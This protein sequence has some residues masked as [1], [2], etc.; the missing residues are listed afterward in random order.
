MKIGLDLAGG[1]LAPHN[2]IEAVKLF[3]EEHSEIEILGVVSR[4]ILKKEKRKLKSLGIQIIEVENRISMEMK[5]TEALKVKN[6]NLGTLMEL[7][8]RK[9]VNAVVS[10]G[11]TG[12]VMAF[13]MTLLGR[14]KGVRRPAL[15]SLFPTLNGSC[16]LIDAGA[17]VDVKPLHLYHFAIMGSIVAKEI[18]NKEEPTVGLLNVGTEETKGSKK[19]SEAFEMLKK[20]KLNFIGN[21]EGNHITRGDADVV[22]CDGFAGN[23]I[24][25]FGEGLVELIIN[26]IKRSLKEDKKYRL[27]KWA[28][29]PVLK[30]LFSNLNYEEYGG[31]ILTGVKGI[32]VIGHGRS[33]PEAIKNALKLGGKLANK[34]LCGKIESAFSHLST[35]HL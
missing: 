4:D 3:K 14:L 32:V 28:S 17:N 8:K 19:L 11:N 12:A 20:S 7:L 2:E 5:P 27:R 24:L 21:I 16:I 10:M 31:A 13:A 33:S 35:H 29:K 15:S 1:D 30:R 18:L 22:V 6:S 26:T 34:N 25:K 9:E 23:I